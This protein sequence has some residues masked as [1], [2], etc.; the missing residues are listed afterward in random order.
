[1]S[2]CLV[3]PCHGDSS[4]SKSRTFADKNCD[5]IA[6]GLWISRRSQHLSTLLVGRMERSCSVVGAKQMDAIGKRNPS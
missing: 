5:I 3:G 2:S 6:P 1:M 4:L